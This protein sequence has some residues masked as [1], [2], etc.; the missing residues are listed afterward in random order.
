MSAIL[1]EPTPAEVVDVAAELFG[2]GA[3]SLAGRDLTR[4]IVRYR[5][6]AMAACRLVTSCSY[7]S[8]GQAFDDRDH[9]TVLSACGRVRRDPLLQKS[10][11]RVADEVHKKHR[12]NT[13]EISA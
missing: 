4:P 10:A 12:T 2:V 9:C 8:I 5:M 13:E 3:A 1:G 6:V 11:R 7:S